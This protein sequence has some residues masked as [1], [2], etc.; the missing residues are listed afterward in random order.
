MR[1]T[2]LDKVG[3]ALFVVSV[4][5]TILCVVVSA[6]LFAHQ[7]DCDRD[8]TC[9]LYGAFCSVLALPGVVHVVVTRPSKWMPTPAPNRGDG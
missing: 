2:K 9:W 8:G 5:Y 3:A 4:A 6:L 1:R 7:I